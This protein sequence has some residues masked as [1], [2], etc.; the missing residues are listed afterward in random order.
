MAH[1]GHSE[2]RFESDGGA[3]VS[4]G[5]DRV[6]IESDESESA[7]ADGEVRLERPVLIASGP[8]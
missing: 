4:E 2:G 1:C 7:R 5:R 3:E 6:G 8:R